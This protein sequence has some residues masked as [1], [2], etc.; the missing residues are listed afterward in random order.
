MP[1]SNDF[2]VVTKNLV[3]KGQNSCS[4]VAETNVLRLDLSVRASL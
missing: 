1:N 2:L 3:T 4:I